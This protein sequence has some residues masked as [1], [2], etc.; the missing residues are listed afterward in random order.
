MIEDYI[1]DDQRH[2]DVYE[3]FLEQ[4]IGKLNSFTEPLAANP[5]PF[6]IRPLPTAPV[7]ASDKR[8]SITGSDSGVGSLAHPKFF[9]QPYPLL[10]NNCHNIH[11]RGM[12]NR[13][14]RLQPDDL[15]RLNNFC[16]TVE[17][18]KRE[19]Q[20]I[21]D[22]SHMILIFNRFFVP[23]L[24]RVLNPKK[25]QFVVAQY[26]STFSLFRISLPAFSLFILRTI[27]LNVKNSTLTASGRL[28]TVGLTWHLIQYFYLDFTGVIQHTSSVCV[29]Q[30]YSNLHLNAV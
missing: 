12:N 20:N 30:L 13:Q 28:P 1:P 10:L 4:R 27:C 22:L 5:I 8:G 2:G 24:A 14:L 23:S 7:V 16:G 29:L 21:S 9:R 25:Q 15:L 26:S 3:R 11:R 6:P 18:P 17:N 19:N